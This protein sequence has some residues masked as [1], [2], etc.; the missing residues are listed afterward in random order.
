MTEEEMVVLGEYSETTLT[1]PWFNKI[2]NEF[3]KATVGVMLATK[4][5]EADVREKTFASVYALREFLSFMQDFV[6][7]KN[8]LTNPVVHDPLDDPSVHDIYR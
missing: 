8:K 2:L 5:S 6:V 1:N 7:A 4:P 3:D